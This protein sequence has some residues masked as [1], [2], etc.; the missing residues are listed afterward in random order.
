VCVKRFELFIGKRVEAR[1]RAGYVYYSATG[2][3]TLDNG[4]SIY[5]E[6]RF[7]QDGRRKT[8]RVEI[9]Y[10]CVLGVAELCD[11]EVPLA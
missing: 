9:P 6:D 11:G 7:V 1:Y 4:A 8:V 2:T 10:E 5:I 3:L